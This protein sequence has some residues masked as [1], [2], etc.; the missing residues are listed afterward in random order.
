M[1][2]TKKVEYIT[3]EAGNKKVVLPVET[4]EELL[5]DIQDLVAVAERKGEASISFDD[6]LKNLRQD[7]LL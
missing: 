4:Y 1:E 6:V 2:K 7:G 5:E 3:D